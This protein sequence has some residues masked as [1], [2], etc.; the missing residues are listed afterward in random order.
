VREVDTLV[1]NA[2]QV[3]TVAA[4]EP[5]AARGAAAMNDLGVVENAS[6]AIHRGRVAGIGPTNEMI[7][8]FRAKTRVHAEGRAVLPGFVDAHTHPVFARWRE[9]EFARRLRGESY[10][11]IL[12]AGGGIL[13]SADALRATPEADLVESVRASLDAM[14]LHGVTVV[15]AKS[16]YGLAPDAEA[17]SLRVLRRAARGR[18]VTVVPTFLGAHALPRERRGDRAAYVREVCEQMIPEVA[19]R[20]LAC[21]CD[22]FVDETAFTPEEATTIL[23]AAARHGLPGKVHADEMRD[24]GSAA[25]AVREGAVSADHLGFT[26]KAGVEALAGSSTVAVLLPA[27]SVFLRLERLPRA[28]E[29]IDA[30]VAVALSTDFNPGTSPTVNLSLVAGLGCALLGMTAEEAVTAITRNGA[31]AVGRAGRFGSIAVGRRAD[32]VLLDAPSYVHLPYRLGQ[33]LVHTVL[34]GGRVVVEDGRRVPRKKKEAAA[35]R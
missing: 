17:K 14:L 29:M 6:V 7:K 13:A 9:D 4:G 32:L 15:E 25:L 26:G 21:F 16:G 31:A 24:D 1:L 11:A 3:V 19:R 34:R 33:N 5:G 30:G 2:A 28:R 20:R 27:T 12:A 35:A 22:V 8:A 18:P 23:R 10:E